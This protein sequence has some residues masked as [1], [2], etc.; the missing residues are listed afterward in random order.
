MA[1]ISQQTQFVREAPEIEAFKRGLLESSLAQVNAINQAAG[2]GRYL[3]PGFQVAGMSQNQLD[4]IAAGQAGIGAYQPYLTRGATLLRGGEDL[5]GEAAGYMRG[6]DTRQIFPEAYNMMRG[7]TGAITGMSDAARLAVSGQPYVSQGAQ[8]L[9]EAQRQ[10]RQYAQANLA[11]SEDYLRRS[12][13]AMQGVATGPGITTQ[14]FTAPGTAGQFMSPYMQQVVDIE[15]R[16]AQ[17]QSDIARQQEAAQFARAGAFG[18]SRQAIVEAERNRNLAQ[19]MADLQTRGMQSAFGAAQQQFNTEQQARM[20]AAL[21]NQ[22][23]A[24][25]AA[26]YMGNVGQTLGSQQLQQAGLGQSSAGQYGQL[27]GQQAGLAGL[28]AQM[29]GQQANIYG[30]QAGLAQA[31][32]QGLGSLA[33]QQFNI[34]AQLGQGMGNLGI[35]RGTLAQQAGML[36]QQ[37]QALGQQDVNFLYN[38]GAMQQRQQQALLDAQRQNELIQNTQPLQMLGFLSDIYKGA[39]STQMGITQQATP[40]A[41]P[42]Q[43]IAGL[44]IAG[45]SAGAAGAKAGLF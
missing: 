23:A 35:Q 6:A 4:A 37:A 21:A 2:Q 16:E 27:A 31:L 1:E 34:G 11:P 42:F 17:R 29:G 40:T 14:S 18:G 13:E 12:V 43:Q 7:S 5:M 19:Q 33:G 30:Q 36:G 3:T 8:G 25:E 24:Q 39:P 38:M 15:K 32:G 41:S 22:V 26:R 9:T 10:A 28:L 20:Q 45:V 44:G